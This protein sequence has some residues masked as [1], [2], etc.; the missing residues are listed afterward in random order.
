MGVLYTIM[1]LD[2]AI[3]GY[4]RDVGGAVPEWSVASRNPTPQEVRTVC[5]GV[6]DLNVQRFSPPEHAWQI[7][8]EGFNDPD[9]EPWTLLNIADFNG[10]E[11]APQPI[12]FEKGW[13]SLILRIVRALS[14]Q[15]GP[16]VIIPDT[17]CVPI[18]VSSNDSVDVLFATWEHTRGVD[19]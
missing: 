19:R 9:N 18:V 16:L 12:Y 14:V 5:A 3:A 13:P 17:G 6:T 2:E 11:T 7:M 1:P 15:C 10:D 8:I 4:V